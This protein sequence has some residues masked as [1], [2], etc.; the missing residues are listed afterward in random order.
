MRVRVPF[1]DHFPWQ[2]TQSNHSHLPCPGFHSLPTLQLPPHQYYLPLPGGMAYFFLMQ[3]VSGIH[4]RLQ[5]HQLRGNSK[6]WHG[7]QA[8][9]VGEVGKWMLCTRVVLQRSAALRHSPREVKTFLLSFSK[10]LQRLQGRL[11]ASC[12]G[13]GG[14]AQ[15]PGSITGGEGLF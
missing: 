2:Q 4:F 13:R 3:V 1:H 11:L 12:R 7:G 6:L 15:A 14:V 10:A 5:P 9:G 8:E